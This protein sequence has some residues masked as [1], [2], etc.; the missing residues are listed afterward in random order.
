MPH[1]TLSD[2][3]NVQF[4]LRWR[5]RQEGPYT[6][7]V[8][9]EKLAANQ[10]GLLHEISHNGQ[11]VS[12]RDF[13]A[14]REAELLARQRALEAKEQQQRL[15]AERQARE[16]EDR[17]QANLL[18]EQARKDDPPQSIPASREP[19]AIPTL[20]INPKPHRGGTILACG[21][22]GFLLCGPLCIAAWVMGNSDL[23][24]MDAG[25]MDRSGRSATA[26]GRTLG[27][28]GTLLWII[29][30]VVTIALSH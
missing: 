16:Q 13:L 23:R 26:A 22:L 3:P 19:G 8:I 20:P 15:E 7:A 6:G 25:L 5:G 17:R 9:A 27:V 1:L 12:L 11:W 21:I 28:I 29:A 30:F 18:L 24:D 14:Q 10:I 4:Y 2:D